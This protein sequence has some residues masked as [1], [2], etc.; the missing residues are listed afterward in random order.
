VECARTVSIV[1]ACVVL[2]LLTELRF[3]VSLFFFS[4]LSPFA[5]LERFGELGNCVFLPFFSFLRVG[6]RSEVTG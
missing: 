5:S 3:F 4:Q 6:T 1:R 2:L